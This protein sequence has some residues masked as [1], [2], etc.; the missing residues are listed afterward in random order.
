MATYHKEAGHPI[1]REINLHIEDQEVTGMANNNDSISGMD[2]NVAL[3]GLE[4]EGNPNELLPSNQ[5]KLTTLTWE[6]NELYQQVQA[7]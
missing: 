4:A 3:D 5:T 6:I 1:A 2:F 7:R